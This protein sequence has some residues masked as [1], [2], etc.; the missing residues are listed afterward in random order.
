MKI[1][2][3]ARYGRRAEMLVYAEQLRALGHEITSTWID[4]HHE[5]RPN[6]DAEATDAERAGWA[7][8]DVA[9]EVGAEA[10]VAFTE[11]TGP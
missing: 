8:E 3:A 9:D 7:L 4:G 6:I 5:T 10:V 2:L 11:Q 1:Y